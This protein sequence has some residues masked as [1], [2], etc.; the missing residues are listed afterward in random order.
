MQE[1]QKIKEI[2]N[3]S[4]KR[5]TVVMIKGRHRLLRV[6]W[7]LEIVYEDPIFAMI[8]QQRYKLGRDQET[9][10]LVA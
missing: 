8:M 10:Y 2:G 1:I 6:Y 4:N 7:G 5:P 9:E 3:L